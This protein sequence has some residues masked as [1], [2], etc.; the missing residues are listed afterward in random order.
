MNI[1]TRRR[2]WSLAVTRRI[3]PL[4]YGSEQTIRVVGDALR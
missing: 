1:S 3:G 4:Q 2:E